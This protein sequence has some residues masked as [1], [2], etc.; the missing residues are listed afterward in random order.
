MH[1]LD[2]VKKRSRW[3]NEY[4]KN[5]YSQSGEDGIVTKALSILPKTTGWCV[6]FGAWDG[7]HLSN[8]FNLVANH[9]YHAILIEADPKRF[10]ELRSSYPHSDRAIF[11]NALVGFD[12]D[13]NLD[14]LLRAQPVPKDFDLLSIDIDGN[15]YSVWEAIEAY[16]PRLVLIEY[17]PTIANA[18]H[19]VQARDYATS[20]GASAAALISLGK[21]KG[22]ELIAVTGLNLLFTTREFF[23]LFNIT[24]NSLAAMRDDSEIPH[25]FVGFDGHVFLRHSADAGLHI[26]WHALFLPESAVQLLPKRLQKYPAQYTDFERTVYRYW[27]RYWSFFRR[28]RPVRR[29][30][31]RCW[32]F[33]SKRAMRT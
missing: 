24:D 12:P 6:E 9:N 25:V 28:P 8:T 32:D 30:V 21:R 15:D 18:V 13:T 4:A 10:S 5:V 20:Q 22:Y 29:A 7:Q 2:A 19:F 27:Y 16:R 17:N 11:I 33:L 23:D 14:C 26:I 1:T 3:L 31:M